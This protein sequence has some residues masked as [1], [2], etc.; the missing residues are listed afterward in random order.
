MEV[1]NMS[2]YYERLADDLKKNE[3]SRPGISKSKRK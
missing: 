2:W 1:K 3:N